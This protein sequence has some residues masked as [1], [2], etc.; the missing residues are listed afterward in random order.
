MGQS[1]HSGLAKEPGL[2]GPSLKERPSGIDTG[3]NQE[4]GQT[5]ECAVVKSN[6]KLSHKD[7]IVALSERWLYSSCHRCKA[8]RVLSLKGIMS[9]SG[10][11]RPLVSRRKG[12]DSR[13]RR[14]GHSTRW[15]AV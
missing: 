12:T 3:S 9:G 2:R 8:P 13:S 5:R 11:C 7:R 15:L 6:R 1:R 10:L 14:N 4:Y